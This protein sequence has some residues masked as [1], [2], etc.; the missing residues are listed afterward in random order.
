MPALPA[1]SVTPVLIRVI[2]LV[3]SVVPAVGVNVAVQVIPPSPELTALSVPFAM[4]RSAFVKPVTA[5]LKVNVTSDV[6]PTFKLL[7]A[8]TILDVG[9]VVSVGGEKSSE[10]NAITTDP[11]L[12]VNLTVSMWSQAEPKVNLPAFHTLESFT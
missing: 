10:S 4:L 3:A 1:A 12:F 6:S 9:G 2:K 5:S 11:L 7:S 8:T